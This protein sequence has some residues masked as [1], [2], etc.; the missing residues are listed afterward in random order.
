MGIGVE[1]E[2]TEAC[3]SQLTDSQPKCSSTAKLLSCVI[4]L[5]RSSILNMNSRV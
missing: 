1:G 4:P 2:K 3:M 5:G